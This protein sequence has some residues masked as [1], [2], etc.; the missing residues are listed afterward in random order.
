M[1]ICDA[2]V[3]APNT[4]GLG[5][6]PGLDRKQL[7]REMDVA[8][9]DR[10]VAIPMVPPGDDP[11]ASNPA[12]LAL[13]DS[14]SGRLA[15]MAPFDLTRPDGARLLGRWRSGLML[16]VRLAFLRDPNQGLLSRGELE[17]FWTAAEQAGV[18]VMLLAPDF[19]AE[20]AG[21]A[22]RH[23]G[24]RLVVDHLNLHPASVYDDLRMAVDPLLKLAAAPN[25]AVKASALPCWA[26]DPYPYPSLQEPVQAVVDAF[27]PSRVF[28]GSDLTRLPC[29][30]SEAI[31]LFTEEMPFLTGDD[32]ELIMG[33]AVLTW[34]GWD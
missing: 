3:H 19:P 28:W 8:G 26:R 6:T 14:A 4:P 5:P 9:V 25:V 27:G 21:I 10:C 13:A 7:L 20:I 12:A 17:W 15:V 31:A 1:L 33:R 30:Y 24:L 16:G 22:E 23:P 32:K 34:L 11:M 18:P 2:Q 29:S